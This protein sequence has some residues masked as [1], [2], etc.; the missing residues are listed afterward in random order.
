MLLLSTTSVKFI[1]YSARMELKCHIFRRSH[2]HTPHTTILSQRILQAM[3]EF[4]RPNNI[5]LGALVCNTFNIVLYKRSHNCDP[6]A[7]RLGQQNPCYDDIRLNIQAI[8]PGVYTDLYSW[9]PP[10]FWS[11]S[12]F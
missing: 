12:N 10:L 7:G 1:N 3:C 5:N 4:I 8:Q 9:S 6:V 2:I 11:S